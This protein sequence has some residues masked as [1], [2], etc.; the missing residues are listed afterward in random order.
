MAMGNMRKI[1][2]V[3]KFQVNG[4][5]QYA[6]LLVNVQDAQDNCD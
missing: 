3:R 6:V 1:N 4:G 5:G 2:S